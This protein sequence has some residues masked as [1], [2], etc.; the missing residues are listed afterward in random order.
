M[1]KRPIHRLQL[2]SAEKKTLDLQDIWFNAENYLE[3]DNDGRLFGENASDE[4]L[5]NLKR[6]GL[7]PLPEFARVWV[8]LNN[9]NFL[10]NG[11][12]F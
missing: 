7:I 1:P 3:T 8:K 4:D 9:G 11:G 10:A 5:L 12:C 6:T 2:P